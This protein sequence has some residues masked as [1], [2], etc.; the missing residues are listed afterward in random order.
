VDGFNNA[1]EIY[2]CMPDMPR[3]SPSGTTIASSPSTSIKMS[4]FFSLLHNPVRRHPAS[5]DTFDELTKAATPPAKDEAGRCAP[6]SQAVP[7][8]LSIYHPKSRIE[9]SSTAFYPYLSEAVFETR[10]M[11]CPSPWKGN[12]GRFS[13]N[14]EH[15]SVPTDSADRFRFHPISP[16]IASD[17]IR[18]LAASLKY[19]YGLVPH[20]PGQTMKSALTSSPGR[21]EIQQGLGLDPCEGRCDW[22]IMFSLSPRRADMQFY[23]RDLHP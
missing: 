20:L 12:A 8:V 16:A 19:F 5:V 2:P 3:P 18:F 10:G 21:S 14:L 22:V 11:D 4:V 6:G 7:F 13:P 15:I 1:G 17:P 23:G 9:N